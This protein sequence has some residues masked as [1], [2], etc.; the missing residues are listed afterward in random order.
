[1]KKILWFLIILLLIIGVY[2]I[3]TRDKSFNYFFRE[4]PFSQSNSE[5]VEPS[6]SLLN[7]G[8]QEITAS[9]EKGVEQGKQLL[10]QASEGAAEKTKSELLPVALGF[11]ER[12]A[13]QAVEGLGNLL[14]VQP[15]GERKSIFPDLISIIRYSTK[16]NEPVYFSIKNPL[17]QAGDFN[18]EIDW[19]DG[20]TESKVVNEGDSKKI[21]HSW[22][23]EG[24]YLIK[25]RI[26]AAGGIIDYKNY[27]V[28]LK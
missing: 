12:S 3:L 27:V 2:F 14:G 5:E 24:E 28:V 10:S 21:S 7:K 20:A 6:L 17:G 8:K 16:I 19:G 22:Q 13:L 4:F 15:Q 9:L 23:N 26:E 18:C 25:F 11:V 1:M